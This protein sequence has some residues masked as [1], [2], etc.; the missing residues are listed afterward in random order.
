[1]GIE[2]KL[3]DRELPASPAFIR[4]L[5][6]RLAGDDPPHEP[7]PDQRSEELVRPDAEERARA[8]EA[9]EQVMRDVRGREWVARAYTLLVALLTGELAPLQAIQAR[10]HF[11]SV[12]GIP[13]SGGSY[14]TAELYRALGIEPHRV[15]TVIAHDSFPDTAPFDLAAGANGWMVALKTTAEYLTLVELFF[16]DQPARGGRIVVPKKLTNIVYAAGL[17]R[18]VFGPQ[19]EFILTVRH[20]VAACIS[21]Y[22]KSGGLP[23]DGRLAVRSNIEAWCR[24]DVEDFGGPGAAS[25]M[26]YFDAYLRYWEQYHLRLALAG[27][28]RTPGLRI[29]PYGA[30]ALRGA[31]QHYHERYRSGLEAGAFEVSEQTRRRH[32]AWLE[33]AMPALA[34]I[35]AQWRQAGLEFPAA[36]IAQ[37]L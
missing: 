22:E 23:A 1:M 28:A 20:P 26:D 3:S 2:F 19:S 33:R 10:F 36:L 29:L 14:L 37:G 25:A 21:T 27:L 18:R 15:P 31:A 24:R 4:L 13:R 17:L 30:P 16:A 32:P 8:A 5:A 11:I 9:A 34:R 7:W 12:V 6:R 35:D